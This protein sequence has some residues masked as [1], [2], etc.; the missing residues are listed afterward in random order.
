MPII[1]SAHPLCDS[2]LQTVYRSVAVAKL[3]CASSAWVGFI[4]QVTVKRYWHSYDVVS[5]QTSVLV[6]WTTSKHCVPLL[7]ISCLLEL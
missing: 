1:M 7:T 2:A 5:E 3:I 6:T 4:P